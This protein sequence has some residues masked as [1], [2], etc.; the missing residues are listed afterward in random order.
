M[1]GMTGSHY[2]AKHMNFFDNE[3]E[4]T[5]ELIDEEVLRLP[6]RYRETVILCHFEGRSVRDAAREMGRSV[7][8][9]RR[10]I[11]RAHEVLQ[12]RLERRGVSLS[13]NEVSELL[14]NASDDF[15]PDHLVCATLSAVL[16]RAISPRVAALV[17]DEL[18]SDRSFLDRAYSRSRQ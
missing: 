11:H 5:L 4:A 9:V 18:D 15:V 14:E 8:C 17:A 3:H 12:A 6:E 1:L 16:E 10:R 2:G 13:V 7:S